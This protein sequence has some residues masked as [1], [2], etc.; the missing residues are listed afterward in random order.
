MIS[1]NG[2][3]EL[4]APL[5]PLYFRFFPRDLDSGKKRR[6]ERF[7][8][9]NPLPEDQTTGLKRTFRIRVPNPQRKSSRAVG[10]YSSAEL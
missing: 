10:V 1:N 9:S 4:K 5:T 2:V 3:R 6:P 8:E 7:M